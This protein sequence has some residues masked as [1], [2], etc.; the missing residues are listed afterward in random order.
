MSL[1]LIAY[2]SPEVMKNKNAINI[3]SLEEYYLEEKP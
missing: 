2:K 3:L 1:F